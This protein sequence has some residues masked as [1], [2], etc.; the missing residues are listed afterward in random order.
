[1]S[2]PTLMILPILTLMRVVSSGSSRFSAIPSS[3][4]SMSL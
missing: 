1:M 2:R 3:S 4:S